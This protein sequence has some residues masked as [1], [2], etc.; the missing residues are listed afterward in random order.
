MAVP[1]GSLA[2]GR[3]LAISSRCRLAPSALLAD[4]MSADSDTRW[5]VAVASFAELLAKSPYVDASV[6]PTLKALITASTGSDPARAEFASLFERLS[7][8]IK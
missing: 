3:A 8:Q 2:E 7:S 6:L 1:A 4:A 5:A